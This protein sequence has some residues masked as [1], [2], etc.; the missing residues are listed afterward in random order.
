[1]ETLAKFPHPVLGLFPVCGEALRLPQLE[2]VALADEGH[3]VADPGMRLDAVRQDDAPVLIELED[4]ALA[5]QRRRQIF[6]VF[7]KGLEQAETLA[8]LVAQPVAAGIH[9]LPVER[10]TAIKALEA[11]AH[12]DGAERCRDGD[13]SLGVES[14]REG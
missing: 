3:P 7:R 14:V 8:D 9:R 11:V 6:V 5:D 4:L 10:R 13:A 2:L 1:A 12:Q